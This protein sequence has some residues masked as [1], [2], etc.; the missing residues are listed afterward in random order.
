MA[1]GW[2]VTKLSEDDTFDYKWTISNFWIHYFFTRD[3][4]RWESEIKFD[5]DYS[6]WIVLSAQFDLQS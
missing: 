4:L 3:E 1:S 2:A 5:Y 6:L